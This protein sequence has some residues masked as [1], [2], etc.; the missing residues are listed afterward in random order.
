[1]ARAGGVRWRRARDG[2]RRRATRR[3]LSYSRVYVCITRRVY[4]VR[5][6][7]QQ[8]VAVLTL[9]LPFAAMWP[10]WSKAVCEEAVEEP[11]AAAVEEEVEAE[12]VAVRALATDGTTLAPQQRLIRF[13]P[14][15]SRPLGAGRGEEGG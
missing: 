4:Q 2:P 10:F 13:S 15:P 14:Y 12:V 8:P 1:M 9:S 7:V 3:H 5:L 11:E 6:L